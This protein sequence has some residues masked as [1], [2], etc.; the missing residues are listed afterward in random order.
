MKRFSWL[1]LVVV[2]GCGS[3]EPPEVK[4]PQQG[5]PGATGDTGATGPQG[6]QGEQGVPG[7]PGDSSLLAWGLF[8][9]RPPVST[10]ST[11][12]PVSVVS[13]TRFREGDYRI[14]YDIPTRQAGE[15]AIVATGFAVRGD[16]GNNLIAIVGVQQDL[17]A[18]FLTIDVLSV[19]SA[20]DRFALDEIDTI[21]SLVVYGE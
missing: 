7:E 11:G 18:P 2:V 10:F 5:I 12:G 21:F 20:I 19:F 17:A 1:P 3:M 6:P 4:G 16:S 14:V 8:S 15:V 9:G 13:F